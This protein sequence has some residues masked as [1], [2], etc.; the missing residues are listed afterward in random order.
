MR[1]K[2]K[3]F[4]QPIIVLKLSALIERQRIGYNNIFRANQSFHSGAEV[5]LISARACQISNLLV[6]SY[7][8]P[9]RAE[10]ES[11]TRKFNSFPHKKKRVNVRCIEFRNSSTFSLFQPPEAYVI[12]LVFHVQGFHYCVSMQMATDKGRREK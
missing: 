9:L 8:S 6:C 1:T 2:N 3:K 7:T 12:L 4:S 11:T 10:F 5:S